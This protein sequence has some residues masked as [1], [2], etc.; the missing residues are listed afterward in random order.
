MAR[1]FLFYTAACTSITSENAL[2]SWKEKKI[3]ISYP[4]LKQE[5]ID[6]QQ[7]VLALCFTTGYGT[8]MI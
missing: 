1:A 4:S 5:N 6:D 8:W 2:N 3:I 7:G